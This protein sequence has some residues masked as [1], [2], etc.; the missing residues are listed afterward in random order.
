MEA[1]GAALLAHAQAVISYATLCLKQQSCFGFH[2]IKDMS[3][4]IVV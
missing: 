4:Y 2:E 3:W 1:V